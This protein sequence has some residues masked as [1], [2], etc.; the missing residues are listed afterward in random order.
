[1]GG[2]S[3]MTCLKW[4]ELSCCRDYSGRSFAGDVITVGGTNLPK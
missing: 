2:A 4:A 3:L 1:M